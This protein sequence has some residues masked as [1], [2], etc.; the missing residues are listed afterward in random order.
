ML[1]KQLL[2]DI[3]ID[4]KYKQHRFEA[5][6][7]MLL[8]VQF[9]LSTV[10][11]NF[12]SQSNA[13]YNLLFIIGILV[14]YS[15][16]NKVSNSIENNINKKLKVESFMPSLLN[17]FGIYMILNILGFIGSMLNDSTSSVNSIDIT[18]ELI[19]MTYGVLLI[20]LGIYR[21]L[22]YKNSLLSSKIKFNLITIV[23]NLILNGLLYTILG[24][25]FTDLIIFNLAISLYLILNNNVT[26]FNM[27]V[28]LSDDKGEN[29]DLVSNL[30]Y[31]AYESKDLKYVPYHNYNFILGSLFSSMYFYTMAFEFYFSLG[32]SKQ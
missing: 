11:Y 5:G 21:L 16:L 10:C 23:L 29:I 17:I 13:L 18:I 6:G 30:D 24:K 1:S 31:I 20:I 22:D 25:D 14:I 3:P 27:F 4:L 15:V 19:A 26:W 8:G 28:N 7:R 9:I 32:K 2:I 12:L